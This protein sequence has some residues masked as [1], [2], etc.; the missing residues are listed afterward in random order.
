MYKDILTQIIKYLDIEPKI[1]YYFIQKIGKKYNN[2]HRD[3]FIYFYLVC[4]VNDK[5][6]SQILIAWT[7]YHEDKKFYIDKFY[8]INDNLYLCIYTGYKTQSEK[9]F[10]LL[11]H[12]DKNLNMNITS[13]LLRPE[14]DSKLLLYSSDELAINH[15][16]ILEED[17]Y[18][19]IEAFKFYRIS[20]SNIKLIENNI[21]NINKIKDV[22]IKKIIDRTKNM[23]F[24]NLTEMRFIKKEKNLLDQV[25]IAKK[26]KIIYYPILEIWPDC[27]VCYDFYLICEINNRIISKIPIINCYFYDSHLIIKKVDND[28]NLYFFLFEKKGAMKKPLILFYIDKNMKFRIFPYFPY[29]NLFVCHIGLNE[30]EIGEMYR[31]KNL[32]QMIKNIFKILKNCDEAGRDFFS[33]SFYGI[34]NKSIKFIK[35]AF[36]AFD[37]SEYPEDFTEIDKKYVKYI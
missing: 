10:F 8:D 31:C 34:N 6:I 9:V 32:D 5:I 21:Q 29:D 12:I 26:V 30:E 11:I 2:I 7:Y 37:K 23:N 4:E 33:S 28:E 36:N 15:L 14:L 20:I 27:P 13:N 1:V 16:K 22:E 19:V 3:I 25:I 18:I 17:R 24:Q 35:E